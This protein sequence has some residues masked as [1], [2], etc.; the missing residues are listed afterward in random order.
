M[1]AHLDRVA[2]PQKRSAWRLLAL[3]AAALGATVLTMPAPSK[4]ALIVNGGFEAPQQRGWSVYASIPGWT[5]LAGPGIEIQN[6]VAGR[7]FE[8]RNLVELDSHANSRMGQ[9]IDSLAQFD[10]VLEFAFSARPRIR[11]ESNALEVYWGGL[12]VSSITADGT[13]ARNT[14]WTVHSLQLPGRVGP[15]WLEFAAAG[16]S[17]S[18]GGYL[19]A[20]SLT[21][22]RRPDA[23]GSSNTGAVPVP[24]SVWLLGAGLLSLGLGRRMRR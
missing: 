18:Y 23:L 22:V 13:G 4:A 16:R 8:G 10:Y 5:A 11:P 7:P 9:Q 24:A 20:V 12:L 15:T 14:D 3:S 2:R 21:A 17:D 19:D 6:N 1:S